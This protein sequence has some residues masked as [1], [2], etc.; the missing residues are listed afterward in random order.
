MFRGEAH[1]RAAARWAAC[2]ANHGQWHVLPLVTVVQFCAAHMVR[3]I[4]LTRIKSH[5]SGAAAGVLV[6]CQTA[7]PI[8]PRVSSPFQHT[9]RPAPA[10]WR[11]I[12]PKLCEHVCVYLVCTHAIFGLYKTGASSTCRLACSVDCSCM[13]TTS[14][15][16]ITAQ[17]VAGGLKLQYPTQ[18][19]KFIP[20][21]H[22]RC[23]WMTRLWRQA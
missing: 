16:C 12:T 6:P 7:W 11:G 20:P 22:A 23:T 18:V 1:T 21:F 14:M 5:F 9:A 10:Q 3:F 17:R 15:S 4:G 13:K 19:Y 2:C 8:T